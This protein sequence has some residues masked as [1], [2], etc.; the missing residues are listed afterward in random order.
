VKRVPRIA[1]ISSIEEELSSSNSPS[2]SNSTSKD[3]T[4]SSQNT[5][6]GQFRVVK[7]DN[8]LKGSH[9]PIKEVSVQAQPLQ[10]DTIRASN[11]HDCVVLTHPD[12]EHVPQPV[13]VHDIVL[14]PEP[15]QEVAL[16][17]PQVP[18][19]TVPI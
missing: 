18:P 7:H 14:Q 4:P 10:Q 5:S 12:A 13:H 15:P 3:A 8:I 6:D 11:E 9:L 17:V 1:I 16:C 2:E 19:S